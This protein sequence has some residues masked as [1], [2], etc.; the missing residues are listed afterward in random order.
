MAREKTAL[1]EMAKLQVQMDKLKQDAMDEL[2]GDLREAQKV[3]RDIQQRISEFTGKKA[4]GTRAAK[5]CSI[6][7]KQGKSGEGHTSRTHKTF[8]KEN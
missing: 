1:E 3:V 2:T 8:M 6:C 7:K 5:T 4:K